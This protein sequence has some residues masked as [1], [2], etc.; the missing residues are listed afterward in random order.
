[1]T[2]G[3]VQGVG[4]F[5]R[6]LHRLLDPQLVLAIEPGAE[7]FAL[8]IGHDVIEEAVGLTGIEQR[9][10]VRVLQLGGGGDLL[11]EPL[12]A[13]DGSQLGFQDLDRDLAIVLQV[14]GEV[15]RGHAA[16]PQLAL[17]AVALGE[18]GGQALCDRRHFA[19]SARRASSARQL[20][21]TFSDFASWSPDIT[22]TNRFPSAVT[23]YDR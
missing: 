14:L 19:V 12:G 21:I 1:V 2:V 9:Q 15:H 17:D 22:V 13:E 3:V 5:R 16:P 23:S 11:H 10:D 20:K 7:R 18:R 6:D 4:H 8:D